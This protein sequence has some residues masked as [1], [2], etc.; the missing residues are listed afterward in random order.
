MT[1]RYM[2]DAGQIL[3]IAAISILTVVSTIIGIQIIF[4]LRDFRRITSKAT[5]VLNSFEK[6][7]MSLTSG[8][9]E[10]FGFFAG[11]K[12]V[13]KV[14]EVISDKDKKNGSKR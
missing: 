14:I 7:G 3:I 10:L 6:F 5:G 13:L 11:L 12:S 8:S 4:I 2:T 1:I 9:N